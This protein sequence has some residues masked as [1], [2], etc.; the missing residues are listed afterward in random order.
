MVWESDTVNYLGNF[1]YTLAQEM[2]Q[3]REKE[4]HKTGDAEID[5]KI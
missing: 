5:E 1:C 3:K 4:N 2:K